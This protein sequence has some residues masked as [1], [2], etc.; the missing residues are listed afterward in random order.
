MFGF[1]LSFLQTLAELRNPLCNFLFEAITILGEELVI[2][3]ILVVL[4]FAIDKQFAIRLFYFTITSICANNTIKNFARIPRPFTKGVTPLRSETATGYSFPSGHTQS[5]STW[6]TT[7][8]LYFNKRWFSVLVG[9]LIALVAF[10]RMYLG[11]HYPSDVVVAILLG[12]GIPLVGNLFYDKV[13]NKNLLFLFTA[14]LFLPFAVGFL[15]RGDTMSADLYKTFGMLVGLAA[16]VPFEARFASITYDVPVWKKI[17]RVAIALAVALAVKEGIKLI[18]A[19]DIVWLTLV[20]HT[21]RYFLLVFVELALLP[22]L[23]KK[24]NL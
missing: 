13:K 16:A 4:Y 5:F 22:L 19:T 14:L 11:V 3:G 10:S 23:F 6:S 12:V 20:F 18:L 15:F 17:V 1:E 7:L 21:I 8:T 9:V 2:L 24:T